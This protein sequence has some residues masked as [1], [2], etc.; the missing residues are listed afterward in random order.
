MS[1]HINRNIEPNRIK[2]KPKVVITKNKI[3]IYVFEA[4]A[5]VYTKYDSFTWNKR[6]LSGSRE[7]AEYDFKFHLEREKGWHDYTLSIPEQKGR[8]I[9]IVT[10]DAGKDIH[11]TFDPF[12]KADDRKAA[13]QKKIDLAA[14]SRSAKIDLARD[15]LDNADLNKK[16]QA[17]HNAAGYKV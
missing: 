9:D 13:K 12:I 6:I 11:S 4:E 14:S 8:Q 1:L 16:L 3:P 5:V 10:Q 2:E 7:S 17:A 15:G